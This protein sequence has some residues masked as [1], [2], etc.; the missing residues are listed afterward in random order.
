[1]FSCTMFKYCE[2]CIT[3]TS[4]YILNV[5]SD[6]ALDYTWKKRKGKSN[7]DRKEIFGA[8]IEGFWVVLELG[9]VSKLTADTKMV[10]ELISQQTE[11]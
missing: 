2:T 11:K 9:N 3:K 7:R 6:H 5:A 1:M 8:G 4:V 10:F